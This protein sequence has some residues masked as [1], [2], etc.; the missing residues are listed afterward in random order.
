M[1][2]A[3]DLAGSR[4]PNSG[5]LA[6][7]LRYRVTNAGSWVLGKQVG[8]G[9]GGDYLMAMQPFRATVLLLSVLGLLNV[10][11]CAGLK[12]FHEVARPSDTVAVASGWKHH[13]TKDGITV[14]ITPSSGAP[15]TYPPGDP[16]IRSVVNFYAD[17]LSSLVVSRQT[18]QDLTPFARTYAMTTGTFTGFDKDWWQTVVFI[19]LPPASSLPTGAATVAISNPEGEAVS[20]QVEIV[21]GTGSAHGF[22]AESLGPMTP[23]QM[24]SLGRVAHY[25]VNFSGATIPYAIQI[26]LAHDADLDNGGSGRAYVVNPIGYIKSAT[27]SD[28]GLGLRVLLMPARAG[29]IDD[30]QDFKFYVAGGVT[31]LSVTS[32]LAYDMDG[33]PVDGVVANIN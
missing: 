5:P 9:M 33:N 21:S 16:S 7:P 20:A 3:S 11:G 17:P 29:E 15:I 4:I 14:V 28:D 27:W 31:G 1:S 30:I 10:T 12:T 2:C 8:Y 6:V 18:D 22:Q 32:V 25:T 19:D 26:D 24:Q 23:V 13:F